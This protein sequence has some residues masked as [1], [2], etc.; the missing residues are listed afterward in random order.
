MQWM[1]LWFEISDPRQIIISSKIFV[2]L[3]W[4]KFI[5]I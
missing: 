3:I 4:L 5:Q 2:F 1:Q